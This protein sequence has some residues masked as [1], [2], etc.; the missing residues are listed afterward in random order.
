MLLNSAAASGCDIV[1]EHIYSKIGFSLGVETKINT[2]K[3]L[4]M[5]CRP[6]Q[7]SV[8]LFYFNLTRSILA[9]I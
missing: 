3:L 8:N 7:L 5:K 1:L 2:D 6:Y 4:I 9:G